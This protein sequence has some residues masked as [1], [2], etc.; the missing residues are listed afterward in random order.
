MSVDHSEK[1]AAIRAA[2]NLAKRDARAAFEDEMKLVA[3]KQVHIAGR[4][5]AALVEAAR[6][7]SYALFRIGSGAA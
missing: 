6:A 7:K 3:E 4:Y 2:Y 5:A 1:T